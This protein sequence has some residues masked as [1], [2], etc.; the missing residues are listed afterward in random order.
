[1]LPCSVKP[2]CC[3]MTAPV[4]ALRPSPTAAGAQPCAVL[5]CCQWRVPAPVQWGP[6]WSLCSTIRTQQPSSASRQAPLAGQRACSSAI[7]LS[8]ARCAANTTGVITPSHSRCTAS[9][10]SSQLPFNL[11]ELALA[12]EQW[13]LWCCLLVPATVWPD[14]QAAAKLLVVGYSSND[15]Y[16]HTAP[17]FHIGGLSSAVAMLMAGGRHI[18]A[19]RF[20]AAGAVA[21]IRRHSV[22][23]TIAVPAMVA[24]LA[25]A[26]G[27]GGAQASVTPSLGQHS[28]A[29]NVL[30][31][32]RQA[33]PIVIG[34]TDTASRM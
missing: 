29:S 28:R 21:L 23:A 11:L 16:L 24:D 22:T 17:L 9:R 31:L 2:R 5:S 26:A 18:F 32:L 12:W 14:L 33:S 10:D 1:M 20:S 25:A 30:S 19:P 34:W 3:C 27:T 15:V 7:P 4:P 8:T 13:Q 6:P